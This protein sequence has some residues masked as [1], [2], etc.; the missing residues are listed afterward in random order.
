MLQN[1]R[2]CTS[3]PAPSD[4]ISLLKL[5]DRP[6]ENVRP[7]LVD[8]EHLEQGVCYSLSAFMPAPPHLAHPTE[9]RKAGPIESALIGRGQHDE[10]LRVSINQQIFET[11]SSR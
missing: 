3:S 7:N 9:C 8:Q 5:L 10:N 4:T 2:S 1:A 11:V 6:Q